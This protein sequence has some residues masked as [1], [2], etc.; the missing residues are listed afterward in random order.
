VLVLIVKQ[1]GKNRVST[2]CDDGTKQ[3]LMT[4]KNVAHIMKRVGE[5]CAAVCDGTTRT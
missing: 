2:V 1:Q 4:T 3:E 5:V